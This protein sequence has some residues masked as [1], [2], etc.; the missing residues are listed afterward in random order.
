M[1]AYVAEQERKK[2]LQRQAEGIAV[3]IIEGVKFGKP[4]K[5]ID[6]TFIKVYQ[7]W[8]A[9]LITGVAARKVLGLTHSTFCR[10]VNEYEG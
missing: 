7:D 6:T 1:L 2:N 5:E 8:K 3:A 4:R 10:R 9:G